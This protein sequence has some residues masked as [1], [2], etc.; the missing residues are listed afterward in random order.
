MKILL[1][2]FEPFGNSTLNPSGEIV[3]AI[4]ADNVVGVVLP[5]VFGQSSQMLIELIALHKPDVVLCLGQAEGRHAMAPERIAINI[6]DARNADNAGVV[7]TDQPIITGGP[8]AYFSTLPV[9]EMV[10][11]MKAAGVPAA[12]SLSAGTFVCNHLFYSMQHQLQG[13]AIKSGFMHVPLMDQQRVEFS[14]LPSM[15]LAQMVAGVQACLKT[16]SFRDGLNS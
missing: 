11:A 1:T 4:M 3:K 8:D 16:L 10:I 15:P 2:G 14:G 6:D 5:V 12:V 13:S 9:K 7:L